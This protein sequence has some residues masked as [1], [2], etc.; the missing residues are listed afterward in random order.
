[1]GCGSGFF[2][3]VVRIS[4]CVAIWELGV[5]GGEFSMIC[6]VFEESLCE[7]GVLV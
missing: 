5:G 1:M 4:V 6:G 2:K 3:G 7:Y